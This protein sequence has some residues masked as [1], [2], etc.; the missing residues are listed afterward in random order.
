MNWLSRKEV[1]VSYWKDC[2]L[3]DLKAGFITAVVALPLAIAFAIASGVPPIM[4]MYTA[5]IA[6][7]LA[8]LFGGSA[9]SITG[10]TGAMSVIILATVQK[11][12]IEGLMLAG[13]LA[14]IFQIIFGA[15]RLG[16]VLKFIP[17]PV[18]SGFTAGIGAIIFL[19][20]IPNFLG[21]IISSKVHIWET[22]IEIG[23]HLN[24]TNTLAIIMTMATILC[25]VFLPRLFSRFRYLRSLPAS[26][27]VLIA[28]VFLVV[29]F[30]LDIPT[31]GNI[32]SG[33]PV[34]H[35]FNI[36][37]EMVKNVIPA[38][39]TIALLGSIESLLCAAVCDGMSN[40][41]H[42]SNRELFGQGISNIVMPFFGAMPATAAI[43][44]SAV[45]IREGAKTR[46]AAVY[47]SLILLC[48]LLFLGPIAV[49]IP[50]A[51]LA[52]VLMV[53]SAR[54]I[55]IQEFKTILHL[56]RSDTLVYLCTFGL[57]VLIDLVVAVQI[58]MV[59][60]MFL[61]FIRMV[62]LAQINSM[63][64]YDSNDGLN[65]LVAAEPKLKDKVAIFTLHGPFFFGVMNVF[66]KKVM[67]HLHTQ[68]PIVILRFKHVPFVDSTA[69]ERLKM[70]VKDMSRKGTTVFVTSMQ[71]AVEKTFNSDE[72]LNHFVPNAH[73]FAE[74]KDALV[75]AKNYL[76]GG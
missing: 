41:K 74:T 39:A 12:G 20:Q 72:E 62:N 36:T 19:G 54:M 40:T 67:E 64:E 37:W 22:F 45:N 66:E 56:S 8:A 57:T 52:G 24:Q 58:G 70:F 15:L 18:I 35:L 42:N 49:F 26:I 61:L 1:F 30:G 13:L 53:V 27:V 25:L 5:V 34:P 33:F 59:L 65:M 43:A 28:S 7:I 75:F 46:F 6:G 38:A 68:R 17:L 60:A 50:K 29:V 71:P 48:V 21:I 76:N 23:A 55:S 3:L 9:F 2:F 44:R 51:F 11:Y 31:V 47:H 4:G 10:P 69:I 63:E 73:R 16:G 32:P 14:G